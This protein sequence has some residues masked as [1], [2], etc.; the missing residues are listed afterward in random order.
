M[1][2]TA[3]VFLRVL[4]Y[5]TGIFFLTTNRVGVFDE[6]F[7]SRIHLALYFPP[8]KQKQTIA[9]WKV[10]LKRTLERRRGLMEADEHGILEFA[11]QQFKKGQPTQSN[12][13]GRQIRNAFQ[14]A[15]AL[16][17]YD[18]Q[19]H[20]QK[21]H[22]GPIYCRLVIR[23]FDIVAQAAEQFDAYINTV[24]GVTAD[25]SFHNSIRNDKFRHEAIK[26]N[27][28]SVSSTQDPPLASKG[29]YFRS[30]SEDYEDQEPARSEPFQTPS[31][32]RSYRQHEPIA[33]D[34]EI[35]ER[36]GSSQSV[37]RQRIQPPRISHGLKQ[38]SKHEG[39]V[40][41]PETSSSKTHSHQTLYQSPARERDM[42]RR[43]P[44]SLRRPSATQPLPEPEQEEP[45][46]SDADSEGMN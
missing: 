36:L 25:R 43:T 1:T 21:P 20:M 11:E 31:S 45:D 8:L 35:D 15:A 42:V 19:D 41:T 16:A 39:E 6:A 37:Q 34:F 3:R 29:R 22:R 27:E 24:S 46:Y 30:V 10:N 23:H 12:W 17:E 26:F 7:K 9:I 28:K 40:F 14:T 32:R 44:A 18:A 4:E 2:L 5:Y 13:N 38:R 33:E